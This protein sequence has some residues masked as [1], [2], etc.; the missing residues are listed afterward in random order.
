MSLYGTRAPEIR[1]SAAHKKR[2]YTFAHTH[3]WLDVG[4][5]V[6]TTVG[7][8]PECSAPRTLNVERSVPPS[9]VGARFYTDRVFEPVERTVVREGARVLT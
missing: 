2:T 4:L 8:S 9:A 7:W 1:G 3:S 6:L 5:Q